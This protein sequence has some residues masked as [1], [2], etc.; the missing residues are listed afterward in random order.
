MTAVTSSWRRLFGGATSCTFLI[1][2][3]SYQPVLAVLVGL[4]GLVVLAITFDR[5]SGRLVEK[6]Y[7]FTRGAD[8]SVGLT[9][10]DRKLPD[11]PKTLKPK[12]TTKALPPEKGGEPD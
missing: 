7:R 12:E 5:L 11:N 4:V 2:V 8:G 9:P 6:S 3:A 10:T 1:V